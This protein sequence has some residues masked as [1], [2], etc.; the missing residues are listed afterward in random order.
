MISKKQFLGQKGL[1]SYVVPK[2][3]TEIGDWAFAR[4]RDLRWIAIPGGLK[5]IGKG[6]FAECDSLLEVFFYEGEWNGQGAE[7]LGPRESKQGAESPGQK[8]R[9]AAGLMAGA[10][11]FFSDV[12]RLVSGA[13]DL[14]MDETRLAVW[15][16]LC[17]QFLKQPDETGFVPFLAGGE[18]DYTDDGERLARYCE[19]V[20]TVKAKLVYQR[21]LADRLCAETG[22]GLEADRKAFYQA[23]LRGNDRAV[24]VLMDL[25][26]HFREAVELYEAAGLFEQENIGSLIARIPQDKVELRALLVQRQEGNIWDEMGLF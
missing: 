3:V 21:L 12:Q 7:S 14:A 23:Y 1:V 15:D 8:E 17:V 22:L 2:G 9:M 4:C 18:E 10:F 24:T 20:R 26:G 11:R 25:T 6:A 19:E 16:E 5:R 13:G